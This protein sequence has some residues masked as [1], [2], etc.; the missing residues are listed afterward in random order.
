MAA[1]YTSTPD[2]VEIIKTW[3]GGNGITSDKVPTE[4]SYD[5]SAGALYSHT[6]SGARLVWEMAHAGGPVVWFWRTADSGSTR[7]AH[8][9]M[10]LALYLR[11]IDPPTRISGICLRE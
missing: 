1:V 4:L 9:A 3:P 8:E 6:T 10:L 11:A 7:R 2:D 5:V